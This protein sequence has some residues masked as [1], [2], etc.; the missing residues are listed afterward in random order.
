MDNPAISPPPRH[1]AI[2]MDGNGRWAKKRFLPRLA[3]HKAG[4]D[5]TRRIVEAVGKRGV[6]V[7]SLFTFSSENWQRPSE[8][9]ENILNLFLRAL[10][11]DANNLNKNNVRLRIIGDL[12]A[13]SFK[14][15][16]HIVEAEKLTSHNTGLT[17]VIAA[18][19]GGQWDILNAVK[20]IAY[21]VQAG[22]CSPEQITPELFQSHLALHDLPYPD[23]FI[24]TSGEQRISNFFLWQ[25]A[26]TEMYFPTAYWPDF[27]EKWLDEALR[28]YASRQRRFGLTDEQ[29]EA[30]KNA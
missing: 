5:A 30:K 26:Y 4:V 13:F 24:R 7:L 20:Q 14:L 17:L 12:S 11:S 3:G 25:L 22:Q 27:D 15:Q 2:I 1:I 9:V 16:Q 18:N 21:Q 23:L 10:Q 29:A 8:E 28:F 6:E 19:Y